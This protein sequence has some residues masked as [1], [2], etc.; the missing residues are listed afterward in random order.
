MLFKTAMRKAFW[1]TRQPCRGIPCGDPVTTRDKERLTLILAPPAGRGKEL[2]GWGGGGLDDSELP[3][4][5]LTR[6]E[7]TQALNLVQRKKRCAVVNHDATCW[8]RSW[9]GRMA[10]SILWRRK[11]HVFDKTGSIS[12]SQWLVVIH[13]GGER[14]MYVW[15]GI[16]HIA[17]PPANRKCNI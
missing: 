11:R 6:Q 9:G 10:H 15:R 2:F 12:Q 16:E 1:K 13:P 4:L 8:R 14:G 5:R 17:D 7:R 3:L